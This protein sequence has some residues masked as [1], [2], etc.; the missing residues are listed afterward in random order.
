M[1]RKARKTSRARRTP[2]QKKA[3]RALTKAHRA[4]KGRIRHKACVRKVLDCGVSKA[5]TFA[6]K[7]R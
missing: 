3:T 7:V 2:A 4:C 5:K 6:K 1:A